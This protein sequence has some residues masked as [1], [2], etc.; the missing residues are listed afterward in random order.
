MMKV[1]WP[2]Q[3]IQMWNTCIHA[4]IQGQLPEVSR[5]DTE[6]MISVRDLLVCMKRENKNRLHFS[7]SI[8]QFRRYTEGRWTSLTLNR[9]TNKKKLQNIPICIS[10]QEVKAWSAAC[11]EIFF[12]GWAFAKKMLV[13]QT[14]DSGA[15]PVRATATG[16]GFSVQKTRST[17]TIDWSYPEGVKRLRGP[18]E[19]KVLHYIFIW[20]SD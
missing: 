19:S 2:Q 7:K 16:Q 9:K 1:S 5:T 17:H 20:S 12:V 13:A 10:W 14:F 15:M 11:C 8:T 18:T 3:D 6:G 4:D